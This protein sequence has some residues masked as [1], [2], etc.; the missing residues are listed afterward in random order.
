MI[1]FGELQFPNGN[2]DSRTPIEALGASHPSFDRSRGP[3]SAG[4]SAWSR[5]CG[6][7]SSSRPNINVFITAGSDVADDCRVVVV[8]GIFKINKILLVT[9]ETGT[10]FSTC[11]YFKVPVC[12]F[13]NIY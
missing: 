9:Y 10:K 8:A 13:Q 4:R 3:P 5:I 12:T 11:K 2:R 6:F 7:Q 1:I